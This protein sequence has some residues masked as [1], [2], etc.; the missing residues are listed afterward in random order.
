MIYKVIVD[1][2]V[3]IHL[4]WIIFML[5]GFVLTIRGFWRQEFFNRWLFRTLHLGGIIFVGILGLLGKYCPLTVWENALQARY[6]PSLVYPGSF[7]IHYV[8]KLLYPG[9]HPL[10]IQIPTT[11]IAVF[12]VIVFIFRPPEKIRKAWEILFVK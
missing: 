9:V 11:L 10:V 12:T 1:T 6:D 2:V 7:M 4:I 3:A 8:E 5:A